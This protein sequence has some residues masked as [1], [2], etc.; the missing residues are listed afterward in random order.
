MDLTPE[1]LLAQM[2]LPMKKPYLETD[3]QSPESD[4]EAFEE[5]FEQD[6]AES[7]ELDRDDMFHILQC[8]RRRCVLAYLIAHD[9]RAEMS[10]IAE[11]IA[12]EEHDKTVRALRSQER[13][14][15]Y[16][17]LYQSHLPKLDKLGIIDYEQDRGWVDPCED[18]ARFEPY[19]GEELGAFADDDDEP[20]QQAT[21][22]RP[23]SPSEPSM[24]EG[25]VASTEAGY[26]YVSGASVLL[27]GAFSLGMPPVSVLSGLT[28]SLVVLLLYSSWTAAQY[29]QSA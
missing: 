6:A 18:V 22:D 1:G 24:V 13:Q 11:E 12:A 28:L 26:V 29:L 5:L 20:P 27:I 17:A 7:V 21:I 19:L 9:G 3:T 25:P 23:E 15:V 4:E 10:D 2:D 8:R 14:R 16:I